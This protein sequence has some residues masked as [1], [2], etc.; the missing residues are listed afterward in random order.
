MTP[1]YGQINQRDLC[2]SGSVKYGSL[3]AGTPLNHSCLSYATDC[4]YMPPPPSGWALDKE[5]WHVAVKRDVKDA[6]G[7]WAKINPKLVFI[8][9]HMGYDPSA[10]ALWKAME[11]K[12][13]IHVDRSKVNYGEPAYLICNN[14]YDWDVVRNPV[15]FHIQSVLKYGIGLWL[16][17]PHLVSDD[18]DELMQGLFY[19]GRVKD[20]TRKDQEAV[21]SLYP[22]KLHIAF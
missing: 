7:A 5:A 10:V 22:P 20:I 9:G 6:F 21:Q 4:N 2:L 19:V 8:E 3:P 16:G 18:P 17:L 14:S 11:K 13:L 15:S 12:C 1:A